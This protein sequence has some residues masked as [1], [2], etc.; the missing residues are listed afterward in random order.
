MSRFAPLRRGLA[1]TRPAIAV[2][3]ACLLLIVALSGLTAGAD[4]RLYDVLAGHA[5][6]DQ[7]RIVVV[8]VDSD[9]LAR[10][11]AWPWPRRTQA[12]LI[13]AL[14][15]AG[16]RAVGVDW[17]AE[18]PSMFDP[19]GDERLPPALARNGAV[20]LPVYAD[21]GAGEPVTSLLP[22]AGLARAAAALGHA[23]VRADADGKVRRLYLRAGP[24]GWDW[25][26]LEAA[27]Q[28]LAAAATPSP[29]SPIPA[30]RPAGTC[31]GPCRRRRHG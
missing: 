12:A 13:D 3:A 28:R 25:P 26:A 17:L 9:S 11:G 4:L 21:A 14:T 5:A 29:A 30:G 2:A 31:G 27:L 18:V 16:V 8:G 19:R 6:V 1:G 23:Q 15:A 7:E 24:P 20:V 22:P 10:V